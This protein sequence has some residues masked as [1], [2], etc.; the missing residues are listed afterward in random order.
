MA[1]EVTEQVRDDRWYLREK[2]D[3]LEWDGGG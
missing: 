2:E 3:M 1:A